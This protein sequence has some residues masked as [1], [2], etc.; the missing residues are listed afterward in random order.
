VFKYKLI[1]EYYGPGF[2]GWQRQDNAI[3]VQQ[4]IED[5]LSSLSREPVAVYAAGRTDAGVHA[6]GQVAHFHFGPIKKYHTFLRAIN[7]FVMPHPISVLSCELVDETFHARF[8]AKKRHY[9]YVIL[10]RPSSSVIDYKRSW[11]IHQKLDVDAMQKAANFLLGKHDFSSFRAGECQA[12]S[13]IKTLDKIEIVKEEVSLVF[14]ISAQSFL[15]HMV[16]NIVGTLK[17]VGEGKLQP[18]DMKDILLAKSR[19]EAGP[20]APAYGLYFMQVDY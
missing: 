20:T 14:H 2:A 13:P 11:H 17:M 3:S 7:Y 15:H 1:I 4:V 5:A 8:S 6:R 9:K 19:A 16:R 18:R 10:N 12:L